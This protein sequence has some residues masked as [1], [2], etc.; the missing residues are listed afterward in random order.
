MRIERPKFG[1]LKA[2]K[3]L[4]RQRL[5]VETVIIHRGRPQRE[6]RPESSGRPQNTTETEKAKI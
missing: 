5:Y 1:L 6:R 3:I 2:S 4:E